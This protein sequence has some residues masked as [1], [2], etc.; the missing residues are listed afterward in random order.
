MVGKRKKRLGNLVGQ[1]R[2]DFAKQS[3]LREVMSDETIEPGQ[4]GLVNQGGLIK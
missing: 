1:Q 3:K 2:W 4:P